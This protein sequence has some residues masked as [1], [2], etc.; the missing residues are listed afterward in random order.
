MPASPVVPLALRAKAQLE[1][2]RRQR[3]RGPARFSVTLPEPT[4]LQSRILSST[5]KR[6]VVVCGRRAGK[7]FE[8][9]LESID[10]GRGGGIL[11][12]QRV[13]FVSTSQDQTDMYWGYVKR[14][15]APLI[16]SKVAYKNETKRIIEI[17]GGGALRAKTGSSPD[18]LRGFD[19][20]KLLLDECAMLDPTAWYE[21]GVPMMADRDGTAIFYSTPRRKNWF[22][23]LYNHAIADTSGR[24]EAWHATS[25][26]NP[27]LAKA[28]LD[29]LIADMT[30]D[31]YRQEIMA[32]F[33]EGQGQV[34]RNIN[35]C[36]TATKREP[37]A[38]EFVMGVDTAQ[39]TDYSVI[40]VMDA[41]TGAMVDIDRF[42]RVSWEVYRGRVKAMWQRW[43]ARQIV[44][45]INSIGSPNF[46]AL[47]NDGLP[48]KAFETTA[49]TKPPL[50]ESLV[51][52]FERRELSILPDPVL[53]GELG[54]YE[55][56]VSPTTGR[57]QYSSPDGMHDDTVMSLALCW[58]AVSRALPFGVMV[59]D[60]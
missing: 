35:E 48:L 33:L 32:E 27:H 37:Y 47:A 12:G 7:T 43:N 4:P 40:T 26:D 46:E 56:R 51:L 19:A 25:F 8:S 30:D 41:T 21:V 60:W 20:D 22:Y 44:F 6:K 34:F 1:L 58:S 53:M 45:E 28:A 9:A 42:N 15:L 23:V 39:Q 31:A 18:A 52:A 55:R 10:D 36:A 57:S 11:N 13:F 54:A 3:E 2:N 16:D 49:I 5:A 29:Q 17:H 38:G 24:W 59:L 14:W 50:I